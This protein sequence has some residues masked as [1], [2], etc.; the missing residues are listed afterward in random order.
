MMVIY[1]LICPESSDAKFFLARSFLFSHTIAASA[2]STD[3]E[4]R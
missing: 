2:Q 1:W 4:S 3:L